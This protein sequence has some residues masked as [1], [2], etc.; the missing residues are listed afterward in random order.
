MQYQITGK[1]MTVTAAIKNVLL[2]KLKRMEKY[3]VIKDDVPC[4]VVVSSTKG[5]DKVEITIRTSQMTLRTEVA[6]RDLY[7]AVD[8]AIDKLEDQMR[9]IKTRM[10]RKRDRESLGRSI[11]F[12]NIA[13]EIKKEER[14][15]V[16]RTKS[17]Y[18][19]PM[20]ID[21]AVTR[22]EAL[23]HDF[24][25]YLDEEDDRITTLYKRKE[26]GYG[27]IQAENPLKD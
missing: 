5:M 12:E 3:F 13:N 24:F 4:R 20:T 6:N 9:R 2:S 11:A 25:M 19:D 18:L 7:T 17:Y 10:S 1:G 8:F 23:G 22:M 26:G 15:V 21:E 14:D 27:I 16:V